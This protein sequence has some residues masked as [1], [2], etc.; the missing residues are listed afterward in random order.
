MSPD[1]LPEVVDLRREIC[2]ACPAV[3]AGGTGGHAC[4]ICL[5]SIEA[6]SR[7][8]EEKCPVGRWPI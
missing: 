4:A 3:I 6:K 8:P 1:A 2:F 7:R 5:C